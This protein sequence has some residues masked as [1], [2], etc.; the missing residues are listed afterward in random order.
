MAEYFKKNG[1]NRAA[2]I[3]YG[4]IITQFPNTQFANKARE[5]I[6]AL[7]GQPPVPERRFEWLTDLFDD[8][9]RRR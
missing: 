3:Y 9:K 2:T 8:D 6:I 4:N 1:H 5:Q 7:G